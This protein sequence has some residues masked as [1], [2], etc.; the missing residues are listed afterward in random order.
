MTEI[1][2]WLALAASHTCAVLVGFV[3]CVVVAMAQ[4]HRQKK[5]EGKIFHNPQA[6]NDEFFGQNE[7]EINAE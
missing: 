4:G 3:L 1:P 6:F 5:I 2:A 7:E